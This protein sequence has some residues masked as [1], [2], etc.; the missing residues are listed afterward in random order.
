[1][2]RLRGRPRGTL[3]RAMPVSYVVP[4]D[5]AD[6]SSGNRW[7]QSRVSPTSQRRRGVPCRRPVRDSARLAALEP[8]NRMVAS[9][10]GIDAGALKAIGQGKRNEGVNLSTP[11]YRGA[12]GPHALRSV[13]AALS[14]PPACSLRARPTAALHP[15]AEQISPGPAPRNPSP[16]LHRPS[17]ADPPRSWPV[18]QWRHDCCGVRGDAKGF[19]RPRP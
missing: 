13:R 16:I 11:G 7:D 15:I 5:R 9:R 17:I 14:W 4:P 6:H 8:M 18:A 10:S 3:A 1:V 19:T 12:G 2:G